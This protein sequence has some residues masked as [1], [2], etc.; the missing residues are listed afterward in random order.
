MDYKISDKAKK[1]TLGVAIVGLVLL[2]IGFFQQK[3]FVYAK[4]VDDHSV[5]I[6]YNGHA[7]QETQNALKET[8]IS[9]CW[10]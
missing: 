8:I 1:V 6:K 7:D 9:K 3:D 10:L 2:I 4:K 5:E